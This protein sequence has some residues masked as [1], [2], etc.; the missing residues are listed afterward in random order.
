[1]S[2]LPLEELRRRSDEKSDR[3]VERR[4]C[5]WAFV[6]A[7]IAIADT[8][9]HALGYPFL[10]DLPLTLLYRYR[11]DLRG[12]STEYTAA[13]LTLFLS[14]GLVLLCRDYLKHARSTFDGV[15]GWVRTILSG[16][17]RV[18]EGVVIAI[19]LAVVVAA[20][21][22]SSGTYIRCP[23]PEF[24]RL[25]WWLIVVQFATLLALT[26][27]RSFTAVVVSGGYAIIEDFSDKSDETVIEVL[28]KTVDR[29]NYVLVQGQPDGTFQLTR[30][31]EGLELEPGSKNILINTQ[32]LATAVNASL[33]RVALE[34]QNAHANTSLYSQGFVRS[35]VVIEDQRITAEEWA[36]FTQIVGDLRDNR[37]AFS[38]LVS[39]TM[40]KALRDLGAQCNQLAVRLARVELELNKASIPEAPE[41]TP[42]GA[43]CE[44]NERLQSARAF[45]DS[46][47]DLT[48]IAV[49]AIKAELDLTEK[50][51][52]KYLEYFGA[53]L[54][55]LLP[56]VFDC[57]VLL[58]P[59]SVRFGELLDRIRVQA[60]EW[61]DRY[62]KVREEFRRN[63]LLFEQ[64]TFDRRMDMNETVIKTVMQAPSG[65]PLADRWRPVLRDLLMDLQEQSNNLADSARNPQRQ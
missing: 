45:L 49:G 65:L 33:G 17:A 25:F 1:M 51:D 56:P 5:L 47:G 7:A 38:T 39:N 62:E 27:L 48:S 44:N 50:M 13:A 6:L 31:P 23:R 58:D 63:N 3:A 30:F 16:R 28:S 10:T 60:G 4:H 36:E 35:A 9:S 18:L 12:T 24:Y 29:N 40:T 26:R 21:H 15:R 61:K 11:Y 14:V 59:D 41:Q 37:S 42:Q 43:A 54:T 8:A 64:H 53:L 55:K 20:F 32:Q 19:C 52:E 2:P 34:G 57:M 46:L 22:T